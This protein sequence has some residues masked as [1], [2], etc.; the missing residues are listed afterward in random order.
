MQKKVS[1]WSVK[2]FQN[3]TSCLFNL[4]YIYG[5]KKSATICKNK[6]RNLLFPHTDNSKQ[7]ETQHQQ[8]QIYRGAKVKGQTQ[9]HNIKSG[10]EGR[11]QVVWPCL[12]QQLQTLKLTGSEQTHRLKTNSQT[13]D[14]QTHTGALA[15]LGF[16]TQSKF[17][18]FK[19][20]WKKIWLYS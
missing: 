11:G 12:W 10:S 1:W 19:L 18:L 17:E 13:Q 6:E 15:D 5:I 16:R 8:N 9:W 14:I 3:L 4:K 7:T 2:K 20:I